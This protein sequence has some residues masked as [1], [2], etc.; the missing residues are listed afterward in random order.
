M[1]RTAPPP[2]ET[3]LLML[4]LAG[5]YDR[6]AYVRT[7]LGKAEEPEAFLTRFVGKAIVS[8][9]S[10]R[11]TDVIV[12]GTRGSGWADLLLACQEEPEIADKNDHR[13]HE[14][15]QNQPAPDAPLQAWEAYLQRVGKAFGERMNVKAICR[16]IPN[17]ESD[18][19]MWETLGVLASSQMRPGRVSIDITHALRH[20]P[21]FLFATLLYLNTVRRDLEVGDV[22]YG[23]LF[24]K[25]PEK[26]ILRLDALTDLMRW[27]DAVQAFRTYGDAEPMAD[28]LG[29]TEAERALAEAARAFSRALMGNAAHLLAERA[30]AVLD[31]LDALPQ[32]PHNPFDLVREAVAVLPRDLRLENVQPWEAMLRVAH[33]HVGTRRPTLALLLAWEAAV[34]FVS[35]ALDKPIERKTTTELTVAT[36]NAFVSAQKINAYRNASAHARLEQDQENLRR[37]FDDYADLERLLA[38]LEANLSATDAV[39]RAQDGEAQRLSDIERQKQQNIAEHEARQPRTKRRSRK[40]RS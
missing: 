29:D 10:P 39:K 3:L 18:S 15:R 19:E 40:N 9:Y 37:N 8:R 12:F 13:F 21:L 2:T 7:D 36:T 22:F 35:K 17:G 32:Q 30:Q 34:E 33:Y 31:A 6:T 5:N 38:D 28:L 20:Q 4:G 14:A 11:F 23:N 16:L 25:K 26:P 1:E 27:T 24:V